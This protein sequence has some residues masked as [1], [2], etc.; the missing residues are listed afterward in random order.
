MFLGSINGFNAFYPDELED[1]PDIPP[2]VLTDFELFNQSVAVGADSPLPRSLNEIEEIKLSYKDSV[3]SF[4]FAALNYADPGSNQYAYMLEGFDK[5]WNYTDATRRFATYTNLDGGTYTFRV[6]GSNSDGVWNEGGRVVRVII[7]PPY[8]ETWWFRGFILLLVVGAVLGGFRWRVRD[9][10]AQRRRLEIQVTERTKELEKAKEQAEVA[11]QA[12]SAF[13]AN[14]SHELRTPLNAILGY[15]QILQRHRDLTSRQADGLDVIQQSGE[16]LLTLINDVLDLAKVEAGKMELHPTDFHFPSFLEGIVG[17]MRARAEQKDLLFAYE[18]Q[19]PLPLGVRADETRL[20]Q[21]LI[22]LL[23]NAVK[24][25]DQGQV[26][27]RV[28]ESTHQKADES[29]TCPLAHSLLRFEV[30]DTGAGMTPA[31]LEKV[32]LPFEQAGDARRRVEGTGLGLTISRRLVRVMGGELLVESELGQGSAFWFEVELPVVDLTAKETRTPDRDI[33]GY[34][35]IPE[36]P[37]KVL[38]VDDKPYNRA[39][40]VNLLAPLGF[41]VAE[42]EDGRQGLAQAQAIQ[43]DLVIMDLV[44]P[45]MT[46]FEAAQAMRQLP[47][48]RNTAIFA[49]SASVFEQDKQTSLMAGCDAFISK[50]VNAEKLFALIQTHLKLEWIYAPPV[51]E[52]EIP[53]SMEP[54]VAPP[55]GELA[56]LLDL[57]QRGNLLKVE[58]R[59]LQLEKR[60][61]QFAPFARR[62]RDMA[63]GFEDAQIIALIQQH[64]DEKG[65]YDDKSYE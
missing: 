2:I 48:L 7:T 31:Q 59:A 37:L 49:A 27:F 34:R 41:A 29:P 11:N 61:P 51:G 65:G 9:I 10:E 54:L 50:P 62:L 16:H 6:K 52:P 43:P 63:A 22:N 45:V 47:A 57:A 26:T 1:D 4:E 19:T 32:F 40:M 35:A 14:M 18:P 20:R 55:P 36:R 44:M 42:A 28:S 33:V 56:I 30:K 17:I 23:G 15:A 3:F 25:T 24:F 53:A 38:V 60:D 5:D 8:W 21:V 58:E 46:G 39:V 12:K 64:L 13:L